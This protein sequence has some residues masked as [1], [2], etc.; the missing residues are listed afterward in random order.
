MGCNPSCGGIGF[1][2]SCDFVLC[3]KNCQGRIY[4]NYL[5]LF[6]KIQ[7]LNRQNSS[8]KVDTY[9]FDVDLSRVL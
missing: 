5:E 8:F 1:Q 7:K 9:L 6:I 2:K 4:I 3:L